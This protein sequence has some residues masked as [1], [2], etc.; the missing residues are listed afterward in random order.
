MSILYRVKTNS[1]PEYTSSQKTF[2]ARLI[3][4]FI[5]TTIFFPK[6]DLAFAS[7]YIFELLFILLLLTQPFAR[8][9]KSLTLI[10]Q[11]YLSYAMLALGAWFIGGL[12]TNFVDTKSLFLLVKYLSYVLLIPFLRINS[13]IVSELMVKRALSYQY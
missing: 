6:L 13:Q 3:F 9:I 10:E 1:T 5:A 4:L 11:S 2:A 8:I 7:V 12:I